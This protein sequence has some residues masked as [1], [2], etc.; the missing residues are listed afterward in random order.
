MRFLNFLESPYQGTGGPVI[1]PSI[2][3]RIVGRFKCDNVGRTVNSE[4]LYECKLLS[5]LLHRICLPK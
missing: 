1:W 5:I 4:A 2:W 3:H